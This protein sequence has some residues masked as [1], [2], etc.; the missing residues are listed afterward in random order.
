MAQQA[1]LVIKS[2]SVVKTTEALDKL[3]DRFEALE[4]ASTKIDN[5]SEGIAKGQGKVK[6]ALQQTALA[7]EKAI[8]L[9]KLEKQGLDKNS[10]QYAKLKAEILAKDIAAK[11]GIKT[12]SQEYRSLLKN[13]KAKELAIA[14]TKQL[15]KAQKEANKSNKT[16]ANGANVFTGAL[17]DMAKQASLVDGPLG[18]VA[19]RITTFS[20]IVKSSAGVMGLAFA[21]VGIAATIM[22]REIAKGLG[23]AMD[24]EVQ[25]RTFEAQI[26]ATGTAAGLT[27][28]HMDDLARSFALATLDNRQGVSEIISVMTSFQNVSGK[29]FTEAI[30]LSQ[31][32]G[33]VMKTS[34]VSAARTLG[35]VLED[36]INNYKQLRRA[37]LT[38][39]AEEKDRIRQA[40]QA[41]EMYDAQSVILDKLADKFGGVAKA[42]AD[43]LSGDIDTFGQLWEETFERIGEKLIPLSRDIVQ[44]GN[45]WLEFSQELNE[46][47]NETTFRKWKTGLL[48]NIG[49]LSESSRQLEEMQNQ[50]KGL[51]DTSQEE[52]GVMTKSWLEVKDALDWVPVFNMTGLFE[53]D[54]DDLSSNQ[55]KAELLKMQ[56]KYLSDMVE[57]QKKAKSGE[58]VLTDQQQAYIDGL[59]T[60]LEQQGK[61][62]EAFKAT[63]STRSAEYIKLKAELDGENAAKKVG[64]EIDEVRKQQIK[65]DLL[66]LAQLTEQ[67]VKHN[68][69]LQKEKA[70]SS[71]QRSLEREIELYNLIQSGVA[72][73]SDEYTKVAASI[74]ARNSVIQAGLTLGGEEHK[75]LE[76]QT[77]VLAR[78]Q[79]EMKVI[80][81]LRASDESSNTAQ[82]LQRQLEL[83]ELLTQGVQKGSREYRLAEAAITAKNAAMKAGIPAGSE[84]YTQLM[85]Q[86]KAL[87]EMRIQLDQVNNLKAVGLTQDSWGK[88]IAEDTRAALLN[89]GEQLR[90]VLDELLTAG[91]IDKDLYDSKIE[92]MK[93]HFNEGLK[94][95]IIP[96]GLTLD[97]DGK[98]VLLSSL[99]AVTIERNEKIAELEAAWKDGR[100]QDEEAFAARRNEIMEEYDQKSVLKRQEIFEKSAGHLA[101]LRQMEVAGNIE[102]GLQNLAAAKKSSSGL[103]KAAKAMSMFKASTALV[104]SISNAMSVPWPANI[105]AI[106]QAFVQGTQ[107]ISMASNLNEPSFAF[108]GVDIQGAGTG[109]SDDIK[110]NIAKGESVITAPATARHREDLKR[111]NAGLPIQGAGG[112]KGMSLSNSIVIQGD[113]SEQTV[114]LIDEKLRSF[115]DRV[116][117]IADGSAI[118]TIQNE[119][120]VGGLFD[121]I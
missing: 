24:A 117:M 90:G 70:L 50:Y 120:E 66:A 57:A 4:K 63:G 58:K 61:L 85:E 44:F 68:T 48:D 46:T 18:G 105:G 62:T 15:T 52:L 82:T 95:L 43:T 21:G 71:K 14:K 77:Q 30:G 121:P 115:E 9:M 103:A 78:L 100:L 8:A 25:M 5:S 31:D 98:E 34:S 37:G 60:Q 11:K 75:R 99:E 39:S 74:D 87:A 88:V 114:E 40:Q 91:T 73:N 72:K 113:A 94:E 6:N 65:D 96:L 97:E 7:Q 67:R 51:G 32:F 79:K 12:D 102:A 64:L 2:D 118:E 84:E 111:M 47:D 36:P 101:R 45:K 49:N 119:Q 1:E 76:A 17:D 93:T 35:K 13:V 86:N 108:G 116:K 80:N 89:S 27:A 110:A 33:L 20:G 104:D 23:V 109:R 69:V 42:Q 55:Q 107:L 19:S 38:F 22:G 112:G 10:S 56:I 28:E 41:G 26:K 81:A 83:Q 29:A 92:E 16:G 53:V 3:L 106:S 54:S 59:K